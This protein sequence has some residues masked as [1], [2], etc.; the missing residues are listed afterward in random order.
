MNALTS[1]NDFV[2]IEDL[3]CLKA[4]VSGFRHLKPLSKTYILIK[5]GTRL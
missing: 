4:F 3:E 5:S 2:G 1:L